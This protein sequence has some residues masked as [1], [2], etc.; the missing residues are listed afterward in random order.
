MKHFPIY[1]H[2]LKS[3]GT[4]LRAVAVPTCL[5]TLMAVWNCQTLSGGKHPFLARF[6]VFEA[7]MV[8][9]CVTGLVFYDVSKNR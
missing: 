2:V 8:Q 3:F 6:E 5:E 1:I 9:S 4:W 7:A